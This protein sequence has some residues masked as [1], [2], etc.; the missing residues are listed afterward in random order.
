M[1][2]EPNFDRG[3]D[4]RERAHRL[5]PGGAHTYA[6]GDDQ[7]PANAPPFIRRGRGCHV[8]DI[9][10][11]EFIE[12]GMGL[13]AVGLGHAFPEV[14]EAV[15]SELG[16][17]TNFVRPSPLEVACA[18]A[19]LQTTGAGDMV[20]FTKDGSTANT[21]AVRLARAAT[22]RDKVLICS[23]DPFLSYDDWFIGTTP[24]RGGIPD[25]THGC[26][27]KFEYNDIGSALRL[28]HRHRGEVACV[29]MELERMTPPKD[30]FLQQLRQLCSDHGALLVAD[31]N[32]NG[33][34]IDRGG[35]QRKHGV[36]PDLS[37]FGKAMG[38]GFAL[39]CVAGKR[40]IM[41]L[42]GIRHDGERVFLLSTT[43]GAET[44]ALAAGI[45]T[46]R[47]YR[48]NDVI[49]RMARQGERLRAG[50]GEAIAANQVQAH[51]E[52]VGLPQNLVFV[53]RDND[54]RPSQPFRTLF[55]QELIRN[56]VIGPSFVVSYSHADEDVDRTV[57]AV[58]QAL[59]VYR[60]AL[61]VGTVEPY[62]EG[63][64][65]KPVFRAR[66]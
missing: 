66:C 59:R 3:A 24:M 65:V 14:I 28:F 33:F 22:G 26:V 48:E 51:F 4:L 37:T 35:A 57:D 55:M 5:I 64:S 7:Y 12:Y 39:S 46:M 1:K 11:R 42:G 15:A 47:F 38:N 9:D 40:E 56:G 31:E 30:G 62:L 36:V 32:I 16:H 2:R 54:L 27:D 10:G 63:P 58:D 29:V 34:R 49:G 45:A 52:V 20:K 41:E 61:D 53:T 8:W 25:W 43:H 6:K 21:A 23:D 18:E 60:K 50:V 19:F 13:R 17:G 44:T